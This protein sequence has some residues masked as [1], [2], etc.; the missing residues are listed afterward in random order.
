MSGVSECYEMKRAVQFDC[1]IW[2]LCCYVTLNKMRNYDVI[3]NN[4]THGPITKHKDYSHP[5]NTTLD[6]GD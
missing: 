5:E 2:V 1:V 4:V 6:S 3:K